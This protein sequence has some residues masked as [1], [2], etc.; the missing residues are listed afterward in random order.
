MTTLY[1]RV[2]TCLSRSTSSSA[3]PQ[4]LTTQVSGSSA[5]ETGK[6][7][8]S[9][10]NTSKFARSDPPP[11]RIIP[12]STISAANSGGV[13]SRETFMASTTSAI[14]SARASL[15]SSDVTSIIL[16]APAIRSRP[17]TSNVFTSSSNG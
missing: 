14:G 1:E 8:F 9:L 5:R 15:I 7:V 10:I 17:L 3:L 12:L 16:G 13:F 2:E 6:P 11:A 4:P